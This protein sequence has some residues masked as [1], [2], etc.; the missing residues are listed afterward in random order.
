MTAIFDQIDA[1]PEWIIIAALLLLIALLAIVSLRK[2]KQNPSQN[3]SHDPEH[4]KSPV[5]TG[6]GNGAEENTHNDYSTKEA[7]C[8]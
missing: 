2:P 7:N 8:K 5:P 1:L 3:P 6:I 4:A